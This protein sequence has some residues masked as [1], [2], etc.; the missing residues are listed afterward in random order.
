[1]RVLVTG[2]LGSLGRIVTRR[3]LEQGHDVV[4]TT[5]RS[6][7]GREQ[8][9]ANVELRQRD[10][11]RDIVVGERD[12]VDVLVHLAAALG[13]AA[14]SVDG[15]TV[16]AVGPVRLLEQ[17]LA[18]G[19]RRTVFASSM[20]VYGAFGGR[21][22]HPA[23][24]PITESHPLRPSTLYGAAKLAAEHALRV[25]AGSTDHQLACLR[26]APYFGADK[27]VGGRR[28]L[29][30]TIVAA[31]RAVGAGERATLPELDGF[32]FDPI[33]VEDAANA[34]V[35]AVTV[36]EPLEAGDPVVHV[37]GGRSIT[38][39]ELAETIRGTWPSA[40]IEMVASP[41]LESA[42][43]RGSCVV[44]D[45]SRAREDLGFR[46]EYDLEHA[47]VDCMDRLSAARSPQ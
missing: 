21:H 45:T 8:A 16:N 5:R 6:I 35:R 23:F 7:E 4:V 1:M 20:S 28:G 41:T 43:V 3:L 33:Y 22:G 13:G 24:V 37:S 27:P 15:F 31:L 46:P 11:M 17:A 47:L 32:R 12:G 40:E 26:F 34:I 25:R 39:A 18:A 36:A 44:F 30:A 10:V 14:E 2:G 38:F 29:G 19:V 9:L 42:A